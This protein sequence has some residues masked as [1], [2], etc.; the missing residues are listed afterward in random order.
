MG[1][2]STRKIWMRISSWIPI[3]C[4]MNLQS[5]WFQNIICKRNFSPKKIKDSRIEHKMNINRMKRLEY[6]LQRWH[7]LSYTVD[8]PMMNCGF[9][10]MHAWL[11]NELKKGIFKFIKRLTEFESIIWSHQHCSKRRL[12]ILNDMKTNVWIIHISLFPIGKRPLLWILQISIQL[13]TPN[14]NEN[15]IFGSL[16]NLVSISHESRNISLDNKEYGTNVHKNKLSQTRLSQ[17]S[18]HFLECDI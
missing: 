13:Q 11:K 8:M 3:R 10:C 12:S 15:D 7:H 9:H 18:R 4:W 16:L 17:T 5:V 6:K 14:S 1:S 2:F